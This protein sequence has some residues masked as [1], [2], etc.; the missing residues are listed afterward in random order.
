MSDFGYFNMDCIDGMKKFL[1]NFFDIAVCDR[2]APGP[3]Y[4]Q[5]IFRV[6]KNQIIF[7]CNYFNF[8]L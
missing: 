1:D 8:P 4:F 5:E 2:E 6:S 3:E 7:G